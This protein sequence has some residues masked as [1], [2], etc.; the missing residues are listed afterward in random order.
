MKVAS[1]FPVAFFG[2]YRK[3]AGAC[4]SPGV[5]KLCSSVEFS[6]AIPPILKIAIQSASPLSI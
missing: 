3:I 2:D 6:S 4:L 1:G 5:L